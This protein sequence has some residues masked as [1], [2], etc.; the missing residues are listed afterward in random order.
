MNTTARGVALIAALAVIPAAALAQR[1]P[2]YEQ[3]RASGAV[4]EQVDGYLGFPVAPDAAT[5]AIASDINI[6]RK[7]GLHAT[8]GRH[9]QHGGAVRVRVGVQPDRE[10]PAGREVPGAGRGMADA[11]RGT[12]ATR[13]ALPL[14]GPS[15]HQI[16][17]PRPF[18]RRP[19]DG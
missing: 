6:K 5:R 4:G 9:E 19:P 12:S 3:A 2:G 1:A 17:D 11:H 14:A 16:D 18:A 7:G 13:R 10:H 8:G 15:G